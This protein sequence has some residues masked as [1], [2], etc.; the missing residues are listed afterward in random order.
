ML[1]NNRL[2]RK[3]RV[4]VKIRGTKI[5]PR[6]S[7]Y[8]SNKFIYAQLIDDDKGVTLFGTYGK[9]AKEVGSELA[10]GAVKLKVKS[11][12]FDRGACRYHG[13]VKDLAEAAREGGL[14]I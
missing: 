10:K 13:R 9:D 3:K 8:R 6:L 11:A 12:V 4:S 2:N 1:K 5:R 7:V 14:K